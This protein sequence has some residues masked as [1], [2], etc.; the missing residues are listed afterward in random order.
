MVKDA[1]A[2]APRRQ[3]YQALGTEMTHTHA[4]GAAKIAGFVESALEWQNI[5]LARFL[6]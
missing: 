5:G 4:A 6:R 3:Q 2:K 1:K